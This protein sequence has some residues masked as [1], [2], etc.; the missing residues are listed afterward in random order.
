MAWSTL[1][2]SQVTS[3]FSGAEKAAYDA[4]RGDDVLSDIITH[5]VHEVRGYVGVKHRLASGVTIPD[6]LVSSAIAIVRFR[7]LNGLPS[8]SLITDDRRKEY[9]NALELLR[10]VAAGNFAIEDVDG[11]DAGGNSTVISNQS[12]R[13]SGSDLGG[14]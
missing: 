5:V 7:F 14:L 13:L 4:K 9:D 8:K 10:S 2:E 3:Q 6:A 11:G 12:N 1:T